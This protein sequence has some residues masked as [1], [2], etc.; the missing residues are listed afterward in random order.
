MSAG[1]KTHLHTE[2][3]FFHEFNP[4]AVMGQG[5]FAVDT[6]AADLPAVIMHGFAGSRVNF[7]NIF[8]LIKFVFIGGSKVKMG[9][10]VED[11]VFAEEDKIGLAVFQS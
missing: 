11:V 6:N 9:G 10:V 7:P 5:Q 4:F 3:V 1:L 2:A 8:I